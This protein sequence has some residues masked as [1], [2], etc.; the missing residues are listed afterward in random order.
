[1]THQRPLPRNKLW[2]DYE[3]PTVADMCGRPKCY[4]LLLLVV[5][6]CFT[7]GKND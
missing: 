4:T 3:W 6:K 5:K 2:M 7:G 1:M